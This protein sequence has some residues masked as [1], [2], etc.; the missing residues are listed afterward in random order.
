[1]L[2][3]HLKQIFQINFNNLI[4]I[5]SQQATAVLVPPQQ[6]AV[7]SSGPELLS[8]SPT[9]SHTDYMPATSS[10]GNNSSVRQATVNPTVSAP[11]QMIGVESTQVKYYYSNL[12]CSK[13]VVIVFSCIKFCNSDN[14]F[15]KFFK[16]IVILLQIIL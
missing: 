12:G 6:Q 3:Y 11:T 5:G 10:A 9:S 16:T 4:I 1:M 14:F 8:S 2:Y 13:V 7:H 15:Y